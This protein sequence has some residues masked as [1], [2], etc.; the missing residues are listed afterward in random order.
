MVSIESPEAI[1]SHNHVTIR[2]SKMRRGDTRE[3]WFIVRRVQRWKCSCAGKKLSRITHKTES[4]FFKLGFIL[5]S[6]STFRFLSVLTWNSACS[7]SNW[8]LWNWK[9]NLLWVEL[10][11]KATHNRRQSENLFSSNYF[12]ECSLNNSCFV[13]FMLCYA[14]ATVTKRILFDVRLNTF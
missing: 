8:I 5:N 2:N 3:K 9:Q 1:K 12:L 10:I 7:F 6:I 4:F 14:I 11:A 13:C